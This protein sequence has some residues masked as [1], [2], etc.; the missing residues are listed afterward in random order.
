MRV[1]S[2][3]CERPLHRLLFVLSFGLVL[4]LVLGACSFGSML[5]EMSEPSVVPAEEDLQKSAP[6][7]VGDRLF[8]EAASPEVRLARQEMAVAAYAYLLS[9]R[10]AR[11]DPQIADQALG[12]LQ[13]LR[14]TLA[15]RSLSADD[16]FPETTLGEITI[17]LVAIAVDT[18]LERATGFAGLFAGG[19]NISGLLLRGRVAVRQAYF[20]NLL[21]T[22]IRGA[23]ARMN[24][25]PA[26]VA[27]AR[28]QASALLCHSENRVRAVAGA[29]P[30][31]CGPPAPAEAV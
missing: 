20:V 5:D 15:G 13:S 31:D 23:V 1:L 11:F 25:D 2:R 3:D 26:F 28:G 16:A 21:V 22:D 12:R 17:E 24:K 18:G 9:D 14:G 8:G 19:P 6:Q 27:L 7:R 10:V 4:S 30:L 29:V